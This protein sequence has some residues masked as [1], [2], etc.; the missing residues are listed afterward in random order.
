MEKSF[1]L[2]SLWLTLSL[3]SANAQENSYSIPLDSANVINNAIV[4][5]TSSNGTEYILM[6][7]QYGADISNGQLLLVT[8]DAL[9]GP[10]CVSVYS[11]TNMHGA[12][13][14]DMVMGSNN[15]INF[16]GYRNGI[17][18]YGT[19]APNNDINVIYD[20]NSIGSKAIDYRLFTGTG[21]YLLTGDRWN[22]SRSRLAS[23]SSSLV[24]TP[25]TARSFRDVLSV[26]DVALSHHSILSNA[27]GMSVCRTN[28]QELTI[29]KHNL[30]D[31]GTATSTRKIVGLPPHWSWS[32][33]GGSIVRI[34][35]DRFVAA[36]DVRCDTI[37]KD[38]IW[39][40][41]IAVSAN[42]VTIY[43]TQL[44]EFPSQK[45]VVKDMVCYP[46]LTKGENLSIAGQYIDRTDT[47][48]WCGCP[49]VLQTD[50]NII[51]C[52]VKKFA[53]HYP[54]YGQR[55]FQLNKL[56]YNPN[57]HRI[58]GA[59]SFC[60]YG[61]ATFGGIYL[62][63]INPNSTITPTYPCTVPLPVVKLTSSFSTTSMQAMGAITKSW[64]L[65]SDTT[66]TFSPYPFNT[67]CA[68]A[69]ISEGKSVNT[70]HSEYLRQVGES[71]A[72]VGL[73][74]VVN[75]S[76]YDMT[77]RVITEGSTSS[78]INISHLNPGIYIIRIM[79]KNKIIIAEKF[80]K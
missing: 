7:T 56:Y 39:L 74:E 52:T 10:N 1:F 34:N 71:L 14:T 59:G 4:M 58:I 28:T 63:S 53:T 11:F 27:Y 70:L 38:G 73:D 20:N 33:G 45:V 51:K 60:R 50:T 54:D 22:N 57:A 13:I 79:L 72:I 6:P 65:Y 8:V 75:Y 69:Y 43:G 18:L 40:V 30:S 49:F 64:T 3:L 68:S 29:A 12:V 19:L 23:F 77:G 24:L 78:I 36:I 15:T 76:I 42:D 17:A 2:Y 5:R 9:L 48:A 61:S 66:S 80:V 25:D 21:G 37:E 46:P 41:K 26:V 55:N 32:E 31:L 62:T 44:W 67:D 35:N 16:A 47:S